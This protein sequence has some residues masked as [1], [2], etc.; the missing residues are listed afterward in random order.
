GFAT[1]V[2]RHILSAGTQGSSMG[3]LASH[4]FANR[5][6]IA[7]IITRLSKLAEPLDL[8]KLVSVVIEHGRFCRM[9]SRIA[10]GGALASFTSKYLHFHC[11]MVPIYDSWVSW[12]A[13][14]MRQRDG[15][16]A[17]NQPKGTHADFYSYCMCFW[18]LYKDLRSQTE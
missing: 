9:V 18:Q 4:L 17:F 6:T 14:R 12:Q 7:G 2:E 1:G 10:R 16:W 3:R 11:P 13:W 5:T 15:L 8:Q